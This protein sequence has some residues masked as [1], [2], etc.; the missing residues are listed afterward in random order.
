MKKEW[1][2]LSRVEEVRD[3]ARGWKSAGAIDAPTLA[4]IEAAYPDP[5]VRLHGFWRVLV[6]LLTTV[7]VNAL[8][9]FMMPSS[10]RFFGVSLVFGLI[11]AG[12]TEGLLGSRYSGTGADAA[13]SFWS[14]TYVLAAIAE[15][16]F[17]GHG[18]NEEAAITV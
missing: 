1:A 6:F 7:I 3:A 8:F 12:A 4:A 5:R 2:E 17:R 15:P 11:L 16:L 10:G 18:L 13:T 9:F 14:A